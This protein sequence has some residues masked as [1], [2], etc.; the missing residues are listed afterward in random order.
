MRQRFISQVQHERCSTMTGLPELTI[1][2]RKVR[3]DE[4]G[5]IRLDDIWRAAGFSENQRPN[6]WRSLRTTTLKMERVVKLNTGKSGNWT[7]SDLATGIYG[8]RGKDGGTFADPRLA[9]DYAEYLNPKL[10]IEV[11]EIFLRYRSGDQTLADEIRA[12]G[13]SKGPEWER[14]RHMGVEV[15]KGYTDEV[16]RRGVSKP[17]EYMN[18]TNETYKRLYGKTA[19]QMREVRGLPK[20]ANV[21][22]H[23]TNLEL[24]ITAA[25]EAL[26]VERMQ[27]EEVIGYHG[28]KDATSKAASAIAG[29]IESD[30]KDRQKR[31]S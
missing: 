17:F 11:K 27:E 25:S 23:M 28:C 31:L 19:C 9:L 3:A 4:N 22:E 29:A 13:P 8:K 30:R 1:R 18:L 21:R 5:M 7:K 24:A 20:K 2:G 12:K 6:D 15:R 10:A 14:N 26:S 16:S